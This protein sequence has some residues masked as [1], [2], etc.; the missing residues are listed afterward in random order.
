AGP[1]VAAGW[2]RGTCPYRGLA[3]YDVGDAEWFFGREREGAECLGVADATGVVAIVGASGAGKSSLGRGGGGPALRRPGRGGAVV[4]PQANPE[5][6]LAGVAKGSVLVVD[7]LEELFVAC[8]DAPT[9]ARFAAAVVRWSAVAPVV[10]TL[11]A[12]YLTQV[13]ELSDLAARVQAGI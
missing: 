9:R 5:G 13:A 8:G 2:H 6:A 4:V 12:D 1:P 3:A 10:V 11:R 7:Q